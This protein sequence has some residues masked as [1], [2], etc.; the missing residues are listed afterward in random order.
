MSAPQLC[1]SSAHSGRSLEFGASALD[2]P[3]RPSSDGQ[4]PENN[5]T[6]FHEIGDKMWLKS[7]IGDLPEELA[8]PLKETD[9]IIRSYLESAISIVYLSMERPIRAAK[10]ELPFIIRTSI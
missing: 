8:K 4:A 6:C 1:H 10:R 9:A 5:S 2:A 7:K 3:N